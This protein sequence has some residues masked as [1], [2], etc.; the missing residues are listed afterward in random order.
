MCV[1]AN[2]FELHNKYTQNSYYIDSLSF[3]NDSFCKEPKTA[4]STKV[5]QRP[6]AAPVWDTVEK[7][8]TARFSSISDLR[9]EQK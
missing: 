3:M 7:V 4:C 6:S 1:L 9:Q 5:S 8:I 2:Y